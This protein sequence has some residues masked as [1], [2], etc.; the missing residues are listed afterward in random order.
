MRIVG[1]RCESCG[2]ETEE[3]YN[4]TEDKPDELE[5]P[6]ECGGKFVRWDVKANCHRWACFDRGGV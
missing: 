4:D 2:E 6:C 5:D 3:Y 1:Y